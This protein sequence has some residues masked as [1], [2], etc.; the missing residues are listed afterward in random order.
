[1]V[2]PVAVLPA[3]AQCADSSYPQL[4]FFEYHKG[5]EE[6]LATMSDSIPPTPWETM[7][8]SIT[9]AGYAVTAVWPLRS[10]PVSEKADGTRVLIVARVGVRDLNPNYMCIRHAS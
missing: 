3:A 1:M 9:Q 7:L 8:N 6:A 5:D 2:H 10:A 4:F